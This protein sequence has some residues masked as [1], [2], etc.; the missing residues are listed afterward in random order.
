MIPAAT[1]LI[2]RTKGLR[3]EFFGDGLRAIE[4][5]VRDAGELDVLRRIGFEVA[6][7]A[8]V[9]AAESATADNSHAQ[10]FAARRHSA[11]VAHRR[12]RRQRDGCDGSVLLS[13]R[14]PLSG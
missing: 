9:I 7:D 1:K 8:R 6:I 3:T 14:T 4:V 2:E 11:I 12:V 10:G 13:I 5:E